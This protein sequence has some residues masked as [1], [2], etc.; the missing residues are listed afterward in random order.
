[1][2]YVHILSNIETLKI[3][4]LWIIQNIL[5]NYVLGLQHDL[6]GKQVKHALEVGT[7]RIKPTKHMQTK[8]RKVDQNDKEIL[9]SRHES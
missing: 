2:L 1:M 5:P 9:W 3:Y 8:G 6:I 4:H 7:S